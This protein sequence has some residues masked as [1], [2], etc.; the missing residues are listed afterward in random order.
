[1]ATH[2][3]SSQ[4]LKS[5]ITSHKVVLVDFWAT[6]CGPCRNFAPVFEA[7]SE[8]HPDWYFARIDVDQNQELASQLAIQ[9]IPTLMIFQDG[10]LVARQVGAMNAPQF[11]SLMSQ[12][13]K[14]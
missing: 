12:S 2:T 7:A 14:A 4:T 5:V 8:Q 11:D 1:M 9:A 3:E 6:W 13:I 10:K